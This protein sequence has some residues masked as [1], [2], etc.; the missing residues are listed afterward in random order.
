M[1]ISTKTFPYGREKLQLIMENPINAFTIH[2]RKATARVISVLISDLNHHR[3]K[4]QHALMIIHSARSMLRIFTYSSL[5]ISSE[6]HLIWTKLVVENISNIQ[7]TLEIDP[8]ECVKVKHHR[9]CHVHLQNLLESLHK[10]RH[11]PIE[12]CL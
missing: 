4:T 11:S 1:T 7:E 8:F 10:E 6:L 9:K 3:S 12:S 2:L 5:S